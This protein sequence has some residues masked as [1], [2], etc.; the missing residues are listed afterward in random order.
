[1][2]GSA[3]L[4]VSQ[5]P[6]LRT[7]TGR[8]R[9]TQASRRARGSSASAAASCS[10]ALRSTRC[11]SV[12][13]EVSGERSFDPLSHVISLCP[14]IPRCAMVLITGGLGGGSPQRFYSFLPRLAGSRVPWRTP[15]AQ[16]EHLPIY[17]ATYDHVSVSGAVRAALLGGA[18]S[19]GARGLGSGHAQAQETPRPPR[20]RASQTR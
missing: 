10:S 7:S 12:P 18:G 8:L 6:P 13:C 2:A 19:R 15:M 3:L 5:A 17:R 1:M 11:A 20:L 14:V 4:P 16:T 9:P